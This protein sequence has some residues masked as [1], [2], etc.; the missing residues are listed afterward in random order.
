MRDFE[1]TDKHDKRSSGAPQTG[2]NVQKKK[3]RF[4]DTSAGRQ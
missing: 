2:V 3:S 1:A 4:M